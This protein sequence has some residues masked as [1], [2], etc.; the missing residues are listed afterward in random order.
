MILVFPELKINLAYQNR[1]GNQFILGYGWDFQH[2]NQLV[3][4]GFLKRF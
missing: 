4:V 2:S 1:L 3:T